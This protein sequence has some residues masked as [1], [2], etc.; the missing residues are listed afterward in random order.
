MGE[1]TCCFETRGRTECGAYNI[2]VHIVARV[3][4][5]CSKCRY[6]CAKALR[7]AV[8][9]RV[10]IASAL[11]VGTIWSVVNAMSAKSCFCRSSIVVQSL[12]AFSVITLYVISRFPHLAPVSSSAM[13]TKYLS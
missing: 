12:I 4:S 8:H 10:E 3:A 13:Y 6:D 2:V 9:S 7:I 5:G 11:V 1:E